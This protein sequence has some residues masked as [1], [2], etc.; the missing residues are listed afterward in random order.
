[1]FLTAIE[2]DADEQK[3]QYIYRRY[4]GLLVYIA[5]TNLGRCEEAYDVAQECVLRIIDHV[6]SIDMSDENRLRGFLVVLA[7]NASID[8]LKKKKRCIRIPDNENPETDYKEVKNIVI[9]NDMCNQI[10]NIIKSLPEIYRDVCMLK[11]VNEFREKEIAALLN[12][13]EK[14]VN[15]RIFRGKQLLRKRI[16]E[17]NLYEEFR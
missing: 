10:K 8:F 11:Y 5:E 4:F 9:S 14:A 15:Q 13:S 7:R 17:A 12:L 2:S 16:K 3:V 6:D 1:M